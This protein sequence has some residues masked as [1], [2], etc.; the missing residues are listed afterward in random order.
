MLLAEVYEACGMVAAID[1]GFYPHDWHLHRSEELFLQWVE[2]S[3][4]REVEAPRM[5]DVGLFRYGRTWSHGAICVGE[6]GLMVHAYIG[7]GVILTRLREEP[8]SGRD[9]RFFTLFD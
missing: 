7:R 3:G 2:R 9:R 5:G 4:G 8:L 1:A 6:D